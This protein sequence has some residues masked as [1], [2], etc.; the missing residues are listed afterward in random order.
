MTTPTITGSIFAI[1]TEIIAW[2]TESMNTVSEMFY[3][4]NSG[5]TLFG[6]LAV[7]GLGIAIVLLLVNVIKG[8]LR[9][10]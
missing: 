3:N 6:S 2:F 1:F 10:S 8:M 7:V 4:S 5:L 9:L